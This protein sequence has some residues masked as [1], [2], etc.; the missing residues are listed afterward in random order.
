MPSLAPWQPPSDAHEVPSRRL[1]WN[2][3]PSTPPNRT[4]P[5]ARTARPHA[6]AARGIPAPLLRASPALPSRNVRLLSGPTLRVG[7]TMRT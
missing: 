3:M 4:L 2:G 7:F 1:H 6:H 5:R